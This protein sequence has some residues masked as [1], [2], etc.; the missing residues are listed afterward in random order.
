MYRAVSQCTEIEKLRD[1]GPSS[2][3]T[4]VDNP[5]VN[6]DMIRSGRANLRTKGK[7]S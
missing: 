7:F 4:C 3:L 5:I 6:P 2:R 1:T